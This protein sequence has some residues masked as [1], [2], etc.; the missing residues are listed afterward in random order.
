MCSGYSVTD[1]DPG[2]HNWAL[3][4]SGCTMVRCSDPAKGFSPGTKNCVDCGTLPKNGVH[5]TTGECV[6]CA[7]GEK[8][9]EKSANP[10]KCDNTAQYSQSDMAFGKNK[11]NVSDLLKQCW[12][13]MIPT[14]YTDCVIKGVTTGN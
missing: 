7:T 3:D 5:P 8:F 10:R 9:N 1:Y 13:K 12:T 14:S 6:A 11:T 4:A 2:S